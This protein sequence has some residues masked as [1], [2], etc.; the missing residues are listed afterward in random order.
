[1]R[2]NPGVMALGVDVQEVDVVD[3][4]SQRCEGHRRNAYWVGAHI[5]PVGLVGLGDRVVEAGELRGV[6]VSGIDDVH[7]DGT[8][9]VG[10]SSLDQ[11]ESWSAAKR[12]ELCERLGHWLNHDP[13]PALMSI[14]ELCERVAAGS[15][16]EPICTKNTFACCDAHRRQRQ[17]TGSGALRATRRTNR[18]AVTAAA[19]ENRA[20]TRRLAPRTV[21][22][23]DAESTDVSAIG[24]LSLRRQSGFRRHPTTLERFFEMIPSDQ[25]APRFN[26]P[27]HLSEAHA[28]RQLT[29]SF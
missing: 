13:S 22:N 14:D 18:V 25:H 11:C 20:R 5:G 3:V 8:V 1:M 2:N 19:G 26:C 21:S 23:A 10:D 17:P 6:W 29:Q 9:V 7:R 15:S 24:T 4:C 12:R 28:S 27:A 16:F